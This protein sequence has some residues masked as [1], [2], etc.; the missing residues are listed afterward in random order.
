VIN[1]VAHQESDGGIVINGASGTIIKG[2]DLRFNPNGIETA[3]SN[4][5]L[6]QG[7]DGSQS[8]QD[9]FAIGNGINVVIRDNIANRTGGVGIGFEGAAFDANGLPVGTAVIAGN[10]ANEN[11]AEGIEIVD[12]GGHLVA[13]NTAFNNLS[14]GI[15]AEGNVDGGGNVASGNGATPP[16][17]GNPGEPPPPDFLQCIGVV[18]ADP[19]APP[20]SA[21]DTA[22]PNAWITDGPVGAPPDPMPVPPTTSLGAT[23]STT[24]S[25][26]F[27]ALDPPNADGSDGFPLTALVFSCRLDPPADIIEPVE[28]VDPDP[29]PPE[30]GPPDVNDQDPYLGEGWGECIPPLHFHNLEAGIHRFEVMVQDQNVPDANVD[31]T[32]AVYYW[33][34]DLT[35]E[36]T[37]SGP[38]TK[39]PDTFIARSPDAATEATNAI[40]RF[41]GSDNR[42]PGL[43]LTYEC[44]RY[45][46]ASA[47]AQLTAIPNGVE[48]T[49]CEYPVVEYPPGPNDP[50]LPVGYHRFEVRAIDATGNVDQS[51]AARSWRILEPP[52]DHDP[53]QT[54]IRTGP[55]PVSVLTSATFTFSSDEAKA[56]YECAHY[57]PVVGAGA[58][59]AC[60]TP[61]TLGGL[62]V[63]EHKL[64]VRAV[65]V[66][67]ELDGRRDPT[68]A[69]YVWYVSEAPV[70]RNVFCGQVLTRSTKLTNDLSDCLY[71]GIIVGASGITID[72][73][74]H[75]VD[76]KGLGAGIRNDGFDNVTIRGGTIFEYDYGVMLNQGTTGNIVEELTIQKM[77]EAAVMMGLPAPVDPALPQPPPPTSNYDSN[78]D[79]NTVRF[80][81]LLVNDVGGGGWGRAGSTG[82][83]NP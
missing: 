7:N 79:G 36:D 3:D 66:A 25:F 48:W 15:V 63:G 14:H 22:A 50:G 71:D 57:K 39:A 65:D 49:E 58:F 43:D 42:T 24:A 55:D 23:S 81:D 6:V 29:G 73:N 18:C 17:E 35:A 54:T 75:I 2:N 82:A 80:V 62:A 33:E 56:T 26:D 69:E 61:L 27:T 9:G 4:D 31:L 53:P 78:V 44:R 19:G 20:Y 51:A 13:D 70:E 68:P 11:L 83:G 5:I 60:P 77:E 40:F 38:D 8:Q 1:N 12:G 28:P 52:A 59:T 67:A 34:I 30:P 37:T 32:P 10:T 72:L 76:G 74:G 64:L 46:D 41:T 16:S 21:A 45:Y 47:T